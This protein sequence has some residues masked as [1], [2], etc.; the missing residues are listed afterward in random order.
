MIDRLNQIIK[1]DLSNW[2]SDVRGWDSLIINKRVPH[3]YRV[4][5]MLEDGFRLCLHKFE[6]FDKDGG[7]EAF[8]H[9]HPWPGAFYIVNGKYD[10]KL[11]C[12]Q[13][14]LEKE[15]RIIC[16]TRM[17]PHSMYEIT[18]PLTWHSVTPVT[19]TVHTVMLNGKPWD[20]EVAHTSIRTTKGKDLEKMSSEKLRNHLA[21]FNS[22]MFGV[23][24]W[25]C[26]DSP[27]G[28][29]ENFTTGR[30]D[31]NA[32]KYCGDPMDERK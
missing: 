22:M 4:F 24:N 6:Y 5:R 29:C 23:H 15:P 26:P 30:Y 16:T 27:T 1:K 14:R 13:D 21:F 2:L 3:T 19:K 8:M 20:T 17:A 18:D 32:C 28:F 11:G 31:R 12:T 25:T 9:P 10:M 7:D